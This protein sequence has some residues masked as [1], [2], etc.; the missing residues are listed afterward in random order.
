MDLDSIRV[1]R[2]ADKEGDLTGTLQRFRSG[3]VHYI[4]FFPKYEVYYRPQKIPEE[5]VYKRHDD[6]YTA[7]GWNLGEVFER[8][9]T[10]KDVL[11]WGETPGQ[12]I[13]GSLEPYIETLK[14]EWVF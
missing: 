7:S 1:K 8:F 2:H 3:E 12:F 4:H 5:L 14:H 6:L 13:P 10:G 9:K 11:D